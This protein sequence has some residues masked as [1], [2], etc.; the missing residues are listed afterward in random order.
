MR[1]LLQKLPF[2]VE[3]AV[4]LAGAFGLVIGSSLWTTLNSHGA[5]AG[6]SEAAAWRTVALEVI[7][8]GVL[9]AFL[10]ARGWK[11]ERLGLDSHW[12]DGLWGLALAAV[13]Y[14]AIYLTYGILAAAAPNLLHTGG[15]AVR[16]APS[17][18]PYV[19]GAMVLVYDFYEE[20]F[21]GG[22]LISALKEKSL[23]NLAINLSV[24]IRL[25][26]H[27]FQGTASIVLM[28]PIGLIFGTWY[29]RYGRLWPLILAHALLNAWSYAPYIKW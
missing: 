28:I 24:A 17:L 16:A 7:T 15:K 1:N 14:A 29:A 9:G 26:A 10:W 22:Y 6:P 27:L 3:F 20:F 8:L 25:A 2:A 12:M 5:G 19:V 13:A 21:V 4:V 18:S 23:P 11:A